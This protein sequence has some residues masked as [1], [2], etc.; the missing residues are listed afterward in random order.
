M[1]FLGPNDVFTIC[2]V[3]FEVFHEYAV[4]ELR[5]ALAAS[6]HEERAA[7]HRLLVHLAHTELCAALARVVER[8]PCRYYVVGLF[9]GQGTK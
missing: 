7:P 9:W 6:V 4:Y 5:A 1:R 8:R 2:G 3:M